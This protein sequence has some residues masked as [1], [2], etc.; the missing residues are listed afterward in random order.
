LSDESAEIPWV[1]VENDSGN[2]TCDFM[3]AAQDHTPHDPWSVP[4]SPKNEVNDCGGKENS[5]QDNIGWE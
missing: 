3:R 2:V 1:D 5:C 4:S